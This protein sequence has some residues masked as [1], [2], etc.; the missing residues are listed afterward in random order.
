MHDVDRIDN[1]YQQNED[2]RHFRTKCTYLP[3]IF[4]FPLAEPDF[5]YFYKDLLNIMDD[6]M[7]QMDEEKI[8]H[9][10]KTNRYIFPPFPFPLDKDRA[11]KIYGALYKSKL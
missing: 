10:M 7:N 11:L 6:Q 3:T 9:F 4:P 1:Y 5:F 8:Y 2:E